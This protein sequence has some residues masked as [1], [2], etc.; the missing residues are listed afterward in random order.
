MSAW[1][2]ILV[3]VSAGRFETTGQVMTG[4][5]LE[6]PVNSSK[7]LTAARFAVVEFNKANVED[8]FAYKI[9]NVTSAKMQVVAGINYILDMQLGRTSCNRS[10]TVDSE[11]C[12]FSSEPKELQCHFVVT[13]IPWKNLRVLTQKK[14]HPPNY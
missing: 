3:F 5:P 7:V 10:H 9:V 6:V 11:P 13:E 12:V 14:C 1:F 8:Q 2:C 4:Q